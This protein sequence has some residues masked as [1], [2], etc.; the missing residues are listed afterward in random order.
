MLKRISRLL[1]KNHNKKS[2]ETSNLLKINELCNTF[3]LYYQQVSTLFS[4]HF[5]MLN[6]S[7]LTTF[8]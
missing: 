5:F 3:H 6:H 2:W 8:Q 1:W 4:V 7:F